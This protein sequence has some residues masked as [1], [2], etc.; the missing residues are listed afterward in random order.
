MEATE[1]K[2]LPENAYVPLPD[3]ELYL[4]IVPAAEQPP[5][6]TGRAIGWGLFLCIV[7][8]VASAYS[9]LKVGQVMEAAIPISILA[10]GLARVYRRRSTVLENVIITSI[11]G[12]AGSVVAGA[13]F[14]LPALYTLQPQ[15]ASGADHLHL[16]GRRLSGSALPHSAAPLLRPRDARP[17]S[18]SRS[19]GHHR[20]P[21]HRREGRLAGRA[22]AAGHRDLRRLRL[23]RD[24]VPGVE[25]APRFPVHPADEDAGRT[26][27]DRRQVRRHLLHPRS[28]L[29]DGAALVDDSRG[30]RRGGELRPGA[31]DLHGRQPR[32]G[33]GLPRHEGHRAHDRGADLPRLR[34]LRRRRRDRHRRDLR[35]HQVA[36]RDRRFVRHRHQGVPARRSGGSRAH[37]SRH[38]RAD[39]PDRRDPRRH[40]R[41][42]RSSGR[43]GR[44]RSS[45][46]PACS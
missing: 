15:S 34:P 2:S 22:A 28:W 14:T 16:P 18:V 25:G 10:I 36:A 20:S 37:R 32:A 11:G 30:R 24:H 43:S 33:P 45:S 31:A 1:T 9:G 44:L 42:R 35:H 12:A 27:Q 39:D 6:S 13:I 7:F 8:T 19:H 29:R 41:G 38:H 3:G 26:R 40:R 17:A 21:G 5:E 4:P 23:L 46:W